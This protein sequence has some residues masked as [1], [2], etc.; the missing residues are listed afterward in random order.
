[1]THGSYDEHQENA[2]DRGPAFAAPLPENVHRFGCD[3]HGRRHDDRPLRHAA[4]D[5]TL[6]VGLIGCGG[7]GSGAAVNAL[8]ADQN[9]KL[10]AMADAFDWRISASLQQIQPQKPA[11][12]AVDDSRRF[13]GL[14]AYQQLIDSDVDVVLIAVPS[15][16]VPIHLKA[17]VDGGKHVFCEKTHAVD[18]PGVKMV[19]EATETA[20]K[21]GLS[22]V[23]GLAWRYDIGV[24]ETMKRVHDGAIGEIVAIQEICNTGSLRSLPAGPA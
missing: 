12:V 4:G 16:F 13:A 6:R 11:Q 17:A 1:M 18:G 15:H 5:D 9:A 19:M 24:R 3:H 10:V 23:S 20:R 8:N 2:A 22:V 14:Q 21:K 7:R